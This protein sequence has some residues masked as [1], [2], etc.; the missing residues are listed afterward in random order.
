VFPGELFHVEQLPFVRV[1]L[2]LFVGVGFA[3]KLR[4]VVKVIGHAAG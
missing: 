1:T 2:G 3:Q 4:V